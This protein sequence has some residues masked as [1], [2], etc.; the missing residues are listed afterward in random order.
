MLVILAMAGVG[1]LGKIDQ[2]IAN[3]EAILSEI[4][5]EKSTRQSVMD[6]AYGICTASRTS[7][8]ISEERCGQYLDSNA[9][10][11]LCTEA[12]QEADTYCW[13]EDLL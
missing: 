13:V 4:Q 12:N 6:T 3:Q 1:Q 11:F 9:L 5:K 2:E 8:T 10:D 7:Q